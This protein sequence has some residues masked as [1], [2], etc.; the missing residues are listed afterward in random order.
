MDSLWNTKPLNRLICFTGGAFEWDDDF[1]SPEPNFLQRQPVII[2]PVGPRQLLSISH[3]PLRT[4][5]WSIA[6]TVPP[7]T[8]A[9]PSPQ[10]TWP[11]SPSHTSLTPTSSKGVS[12]APTSTHKQSGTSRIWT[13]DLVSCFLSQEV[14]KMERKIKQSIGHV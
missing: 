4:T 6:G 5:P 13:L 2:L 7:T 3:H 10:P 12:S 11:T 8:H 9:S 14:V 1:S